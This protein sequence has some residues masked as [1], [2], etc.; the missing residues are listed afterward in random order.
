ME[1]AAGLHYRTLRS[2]YLCSSQAGR[3]SDSGSVFVREASFISR[4]RRPGGLMPQLLSSTRAI[5]PA[6]R[7]ASWGSNRRVLF[8]D[9]AGPVVK[10]HNSYRPPGDSPASRSASWG[11]N[12]RV[13]FRDGAG[14]VVNATTPIVRRAIRRRA[15][16]RRGRSNRRVLFRD[17]AGP[18]I[19]C[20]NNC[21][22]APAIRRRAGARRGGQTIETSSISR[23]RR[24]VDRVP[25]QL[26]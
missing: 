26:P 9:G 4:R 16:A 6:S 1:Q 18:L 24:P 22:S 17:G 12:R 10:C 15:G 13:L 8:R 11:S 25:Q 2:A 21:H 23:R 3:T 14:P 19:E 5:R 20:H 7:S